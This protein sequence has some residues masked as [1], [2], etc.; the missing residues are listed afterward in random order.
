[1][2]QQSAAWRAQLTAAGG[3]HTWRSPLRQSWVTD[4]VRLSLRAPRTT[5]VLQCVREAASYLTRLRWNRAASC[6]ITLTSRHEKADEESQLTFRIQ[7]FG[8]GVCSPSC[9]LAPVF[10][11]QPPDV[12]GVRQQRLTLFTFER[13]SRQTSALSVTDAAGADVLLSGLP[14]G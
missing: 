8:N 13:S 10:C 9:L 6:K 7:M 3:K 14:I 1:M 12:W 5:L 4:A 2:R 11:S